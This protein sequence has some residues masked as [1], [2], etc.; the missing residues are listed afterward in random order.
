M[1]APKGRQILTSQREN[2]GRGLPLQSRLPA[3]NGLDGI[4]WAEGVHIWHR[5]QRSQLLDRLVG[6]PVFAKADRIVRE[7]MAD[8]DS[9]Q[10]GEAQ[11]RAAII[12]EDAKHR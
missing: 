1:G 8:P 2:R 4:G 12:W 10:R 7:G 9:H 3:L 6:R 5:A 11:R